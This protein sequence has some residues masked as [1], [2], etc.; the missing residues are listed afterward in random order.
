[1]K[2]I[3]PFGAARGLRQ[4]DHMSPYLFVIAMEYLSRCLNVLRGNKGFKFHPKCA[5]LNI[6][7]LSFAD[8]L[9]MFARGD[10]RYVAE[11]Q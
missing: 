10:L 3:E 2:H 9:V 11:L 4:G 1:M 5:K 8:D 7:H 6:T